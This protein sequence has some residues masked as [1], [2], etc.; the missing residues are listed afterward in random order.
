MLSLLVR[1]VY[2]GGQT[3]QGCYLGLTMLNTQSINQV[4]EMGSFQSSSFSQAE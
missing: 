3:A 4:L 2:G 1:I